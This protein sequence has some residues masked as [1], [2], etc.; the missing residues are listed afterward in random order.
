MKGLIWQNMLKSKMKNLK[1]VMSGYVSKV[2]TAHREKWV[3][4]F[5][6]ERRERERERERYR[7]SE[8][9]RERERESK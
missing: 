2:I 4:E 9:E 8:R 1:R 7:E 6:R 5:V 3:C